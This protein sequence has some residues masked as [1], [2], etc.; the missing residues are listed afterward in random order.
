MAAT[1]PSSFVQGMLSGA[2]RTL[3]QAQLAGIAPALLEVPAVR[4][5]RQQFVRLY[6]GLALGMGDEML[7]LWSRAHRVPR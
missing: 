2:R 7:G 1:V 5:T 4:I 6:A 3:G